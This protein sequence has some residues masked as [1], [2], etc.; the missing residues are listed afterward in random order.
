M[1]V[2][3]LLEILNGSPLL[4][5]HC[6]E[7]AALIWDSA[8]TFFDRCEAF[9]EEFMVQMSTAVEFHVRSQFDILL[10]VASS[11]CLSRLLVEGIQVVHV[12]AVVLSI[13][14]LHKV[15]GDDWL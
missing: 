5:D 6:P 11:Q 15:A 2:K 3:D 10:D 1:L 4:L 12:G 9:P 14:E 7:I 8:T 13:V